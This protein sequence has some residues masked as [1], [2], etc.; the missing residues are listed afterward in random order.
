MQ[1]RALHQLLQR[2]LEGEG[3]GSHHMCCRGHASQMHPSRHAPRAAPGLPPA[4][5]RHAPQQPFPFLSVI[6]AGEAQPLE[7]SRFPVPLPPGAVR[8]GVV[9]FQVGSCC[10]LAPG[11]M[12]GG[13]V[14]LQEAWLQGAVPSRPAGVFLSAILEHLKT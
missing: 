14:F 3:E 5:Q 1:H 12:V 4:A 7:Y 9:F 11:A 10:C 8:L 2:N 13:Q 6:P